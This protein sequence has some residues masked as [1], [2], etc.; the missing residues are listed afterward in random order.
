LKLNSVLILVFL[1]VMVFG[2]SKAVAQ[3]T[4]STDVPKGTS[5]VIID[6]KALPQVKMTTKYGDMIIE[7][8]ED[9]TPNTVANFVNLIE[10]GYYD[11]LTFHRVVANFVIQGGDPTGTGSGGPGYRIRC[12]CEK[13]THKHLRG[14]LSMAHAG[15]DTGGSQFFITHCA[16]PHLD[17]RHTVFGQVLTGVEIVDKVQ[18]D[19]KMEK[20]VM[21]KKRSHEYK[22]E[23]LSK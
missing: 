1:F 18:K 16:T 14:V 17:G 8:F 6:D 9:E 19:D 10:K 3:D 23:T 21:L 15:K 20:V 7:L 4:K 22:P 2:V 11:G 5:E 13:N 12:E